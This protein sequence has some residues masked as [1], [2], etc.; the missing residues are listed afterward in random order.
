MEELEGPQAL[1]KDR[2][3]TVNK[4]LDS[5]FSELESMLKTLLAQMQGVN[6][7]LVGNEFNH[8]EPK[9]GMILGQPGTIP[10]WGKSMENGKCYFCGKMGH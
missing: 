2:L 10:R 8:P 5:K 1:E 3:V 6:K 4:Q 7:A 9:P